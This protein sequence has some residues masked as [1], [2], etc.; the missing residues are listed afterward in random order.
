MGEAGTAKKVSVQR[1]RRHLEFTYGVWGMQ[2]PG[3]CASLLFLSPGVACSDKVLETALPRLSG[4]GLEWVTEFGDGSK[5]SRVGVQ[6][7]ALVM[8]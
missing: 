8:V 6:Y 2:L 7:S 5:G 1:G 4:C 3:L